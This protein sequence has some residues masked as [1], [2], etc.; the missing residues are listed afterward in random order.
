MP[1]KEEQT[2]GT[3]G[4]NKVE[5]TWRPQLPGTSKIPFHF[6]RPLV[7]TQKMPTPLLKWGFFLSIGTME[8]LEQWL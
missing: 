8:Q 6:S 2:L 7:P 3:R 5:L 1:E 4:W